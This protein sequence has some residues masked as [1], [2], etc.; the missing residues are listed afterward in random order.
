MF[1]VLYKVASIILLSYFPVR[2]F[3]LYIFKAIKKKALILLYVVRKSKEQEETYMSKQ[4]IGGSCSVILY[5]QLS[6]LS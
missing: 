5:S 4:F 2:C 6:S 1:N 3:P